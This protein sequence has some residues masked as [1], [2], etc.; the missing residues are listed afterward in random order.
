MGPERTIEVFVASAQTATNILFQQGAS[1]RQ[2]VFEEGGGVGVHFPVFGSGS[3]GF[4]FQRLQSFLCQ[5]SGSWCDWKRYL[6]WGER[7]QQSPCLVD[8]SSSSF[9][10]AYYH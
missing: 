2:A 8:F 4:S 1:K 5:Q 7:P 10:D 3:S 9:F 6:P